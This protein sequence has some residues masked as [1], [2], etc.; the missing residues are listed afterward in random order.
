VYWAKPFTLV[1][2][3]IIYLLVYVDRTL[4]PLYYYLCEIQKNPGIWGFLAR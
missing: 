3:D 2:A 1:V 4:R